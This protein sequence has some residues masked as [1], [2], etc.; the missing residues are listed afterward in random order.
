MLGTIWSR[1]QWSGSDDTSPRRGDHFDQRITNLIAFPDSVPLIR[2]VHSSL[3]RLLLE[4]MRR[5]W[6]PATPEL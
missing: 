5:G 3:G 1:G 2:T 6:A 4:E